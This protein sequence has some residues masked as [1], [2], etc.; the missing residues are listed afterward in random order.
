MLNGK[1]ITPFTFPFA[2]IDLNTQHD[3]FDPAGATPVVYAEGL[4]TPLRRVVAWMKRNHIPVVSTMQT[5]RHRDTQP[6]R[7]IA[8]TPG[9]TKIDYTLL[10]SRIFVAGDN[11]LAIATDLF[12]RYQQVIFPKRSLDLF[13]NPKADRFLTQVRVDEFIVFGAL[14]EQDVKAVTLGLLARNKKVSVISDACGCWNQM[15]ADLSLRQVEAKGATLLTIDELT[16][17]K[18]RRRWYDGE[19]RFIA[20]NRPATRIDPQLLQSD[21]NRP[22]SS[23]SLRQFG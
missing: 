10:P 22:G 23:E 2:L 1:K 16:E 13:A 9:H 7:C 14:C 5:H 4:R 3:F 19:A 6:E 21:I 11:T 20:E 15:E 17:R 18:V 12:R 8:G